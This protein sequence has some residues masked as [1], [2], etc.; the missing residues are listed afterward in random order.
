MRALPDHRGPLVPGRKLLVGG[1]NRRQRS[2]TSR[3]TQHQH[4]IP[5]HTH[6]H[7]SL[8]AAQ[9]HALLVAQGFGG[10]DAGRGPGGINRSDKRDTHCD[11]RDQNAVDQARRKRNVIDGV[12]PRAPAR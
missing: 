9:D 11:Q 2:S 8:W 10:Q 4:P 12:K 1:L 3:A 6:F 7:P 5:N